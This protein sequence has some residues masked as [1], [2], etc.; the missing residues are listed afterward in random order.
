MAT[1]AHPA[2]REYRQRQQDAGCAPTHIAATTVTTHTD[3]TLKTSSNR[4]QIHKRHT[5]AEVPL[6]PPARQPYACP[7]SPTVKLCTSPSRLTLAAL[8][9]LPALMSAEDALTVLPS[10]NVGI[11]TTSPSERLHVIGNARVDGSL[12]IASSTS[13]DSLIGADH[14][15]GYL[16]FGTGQFLVVRTHDATTGEYAEIGKWTDAGLRTVGGIT[17]NNSEWSNLTIETD[18][19]TRTKDPILHF[20]APNPN[21]GFTK[22]E[23][24]IHHDQSENNRLDIRYDNTSKLQILTSGALVLSGPIDNWNFQINGPNFQLGLDDGRDIG[25]KP[26]QRAFAHVGNDT[27]ALN[28]AGDFEGGVRI[29]SQVSVDG[30]LTARSGIALGTDPA[31]QLVDQVVTSLDENATNAQIPTASAV[32]AYVDQALANTAEPVV[33]HAASDAAQAIPT[34]VTTVLNFEDVLVDSHGLV[35]PGSGWHLTA[36]RDMTLNVS[37][38]ARFGSVPVSTAFEPSFRVNGAIVR[39]TT[40]WSSPAGPTSPSAQLSATITLH[41]G[42]TLDATLRQVSNGTRTLSGQRHQVFFDASEVR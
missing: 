41:A 2:A 27:L 35:T 16:S 29:D 18:D 20:R 22:N 21:T 15:K 25:T 31:A 24:A 7:W 42:D 34:S 36:T 33:I 10:G 39:T 17:V 38:G 28:Y 13:G 23:W 14:G 26:D 11:G 1:S 3:R 30:T 4:L 37:M 9:L 8:L 19:P 40:T 12:G 6:Q 5:P 32:T